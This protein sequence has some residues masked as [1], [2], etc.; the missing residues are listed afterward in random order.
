[1]AQATSSDRFFPPLGSPQEEL[2]HFRDRVIN[3]WSMYRNRHMG[4]IA[5]S[6]WYH[7]GRQWAEF[8]AEAMFDGV[9]G[10]ILRDADM[11]QVPRPVINE[12][13]YAMEAEMVKLA[14]RKWIP[15]ITPT[16]KDPR[17]K[18]AAQVAKDQLNYRLEQLEW[19]M[20]RRMN[21][22]H[23][24][25]GGT[26]LL[27]S[28][29]DKSY[30]EL[31]TI[32]APTAVYC[33]QCKLKLYSPEIPI[34]LLQ[35]G[36]GGQPLSNTSTIRSV[37]PEPGSSEQ[38]L[39][40]V[41]C[42]VCQNPSELGHYEPTAQEARESDDVFGRPL[43]IQEPRGGTEIEADIPFE[44]HPQNGGAR[45]SPFSMK[46]FGRRKI[47][48]L[49]WVEERYPHLVHLVSPDSP[50]ELLY[51]DPMLGE[52]SILGRWSATLDVGILDNHV[53]VDEVVEQPSFRNPHGRY[54]VCTRDLVLEDANLLER[55]VEAGD[56]SGPL[57]V[58]R[59]Q[60][61]VSRYK[62]RPLEIW[63]TTGVDNAI[64][65]QNRLN[66]IDSQLIETRERLGTPNLFMPA[67]MWLDNPVR[68]VDG[69]GGAKIFLF[70]PSL[71]NPQFSKPEIFGGTLYPQD[72]YMERDRVQNDLRRLMGPSDVSQGMAPKNVG[73]TSGL[74]MLLEQDEASRSLREDE[75]V[76]SAEKCWSH[77]LQLEWVLRV[78]E[79]VYRVLGPDRAWSYRQYT[80]MTLR[81]QTEVKIE[82]APFVAK[83]V[84]RREAA[85]EA[86]A[87]GL[88][89]PDSPTSRRHLLEAYGLGD[90]DV[91]VNEDETNQIDQ[92]ERQWV[93][94]VDSGIVRVQDSIDDPSIRYKVLGTMLLSEEG[95]RITNEAGWD[96]IMRVIA[97]WEQELQR[98]SA[99]EQ[100]AIAFYGGRIEGRE[101]QE[102]YAKAMVSWDEQVAVYQQQIQTYNQMMAMPGAQAG[103]PPMMPPKPPPPL[104]LPALL[105]DRI[106]T[107]W[108]GMLQKAQIVLDQPQAPLAPPPV[109]PRS[110][111]V[112]F[113]ALI[114]AY[115]LSSAGPMIAPPPNAVAPQSAAPGL[116]G[117][118]PG[119]MTPANTGGVGA[120]PPVASLPEGGRR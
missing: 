37:E 118:P 42:P 99:L 45:I 102:A 21:A 97:G 29:W 6:F 117:P 24:G 51:D 12:I 64:S 22:L 79:D 112:K 85:R 15:T 109:R 90:L 89:S 75:F 62:L 67:D 98:A 9:R 14:S 106:L 50:A 4:R 25:V 65:P 84:V 111:Y 103:T 72:V 40:L 53:N 60:M 43:G 105:Q 83:S 49:E 23:F 116:P 30:F 31:H 71:S 10:A 88:I 96:E 93:D 119:A 120:P 86:I 13:D 87:D 74:Q 46:R 78:D 1:M 28:S 63:G 101:A 27:Y 108:G 8:D 47:R 91:P 80:G 18:A 107:I 2:L 66:G 56:G 57:Y 3:R 61:A 17:I 33:P 110:T 59:V 104:F 69:W 26:G 73:T 58:P 44:F 77:T 70:N 55:G 16:S 113:R 100:Q 114:E 19:G 7:L 54:I 115:R 52:W 94:F 81:G 11:S 35:S 39:H 95:Q 38:L 48:S 32:G 92:A 5:L 82:R 34:D 20:K 36:I 68:M 41:H 76:G